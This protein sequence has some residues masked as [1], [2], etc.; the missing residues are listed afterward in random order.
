VDL[1]QALPDVAK[2]W[3]VVFDSPLVLIIQIPD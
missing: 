2:N 1:H 3:P